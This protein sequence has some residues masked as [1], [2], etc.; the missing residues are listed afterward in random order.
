MTIPGNEISSLY[1]LQ[2]ERSE[3]ALA[4]QGSV[5]ISSA[6]LMGKRN[7]VIIQHLGEH[8]ILR[9]TRAGKLI[10]TK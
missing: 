4:T 1:P 7:Q 3:C 6:D 2:R 8:Y 5:Q 10:L 9:Q